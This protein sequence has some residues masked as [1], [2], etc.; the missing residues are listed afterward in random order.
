V[1]YYWFRRR[2]QELGNATEATNIQETRG[3]LSYCGLMSKKGVKLL[4]G[5]V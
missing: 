5:N 2:L 4:S 1:E 3:R